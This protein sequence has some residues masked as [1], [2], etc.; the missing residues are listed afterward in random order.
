MY[1]NRDN[2]DVYDDDD[3]DD[4]M[5]DG[6][7]DGSDGDVGDIDDDSGGDNTANC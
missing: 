2:G 7:Y 6:D 5:Y 1:S 4:S 3:G